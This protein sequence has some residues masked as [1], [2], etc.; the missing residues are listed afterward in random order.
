MNWDSMSSEPYELAF[1]NNALKNLKRLDK[2]VASRI[3]KKL[4]TLAKEV[5][6]FPHTAMK[7]QWK[8]YFRI[9]VGNY[10]VIYDL[11]HDNQRIIIETVGHRR[12]IYE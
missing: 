10:R 6:S 5:E 2:G 9:R 1:E 7:G 3:L 11:D 8:G 12:D 4:Q